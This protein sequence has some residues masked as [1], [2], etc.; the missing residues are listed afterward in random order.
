MHLHYGFTTFVPNNTILDMSQLKQ[1]T[2]L[3]VNITQELKF[4]LHLE[5]NIVGKGFSLCTSYFQK[6]SP[7]GLFKVDIVWLTHSHS[8]TPFD[9]PGKQSF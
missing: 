3:I 2:Y 8:M 9:A 5:E 4:A 7:C 6:L 1:F